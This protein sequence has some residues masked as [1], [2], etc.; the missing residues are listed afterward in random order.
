IKKDSKRKLKNLQ[1]NT[2]VFKE[3]GGQYI[4]SAIPIENSE[5]IK[6]SLDKVFESKSSAWKIYLY[7]TL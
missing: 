4:L 1:L 7:K 6:L 2:S 3:M 5:K